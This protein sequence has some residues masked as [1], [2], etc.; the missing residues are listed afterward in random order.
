MADDPPFREGEP[1]TA[2]L[3][4]KALDCTV[5]RETFEAGDPPHCPSS[6]LLRRR[7][8]GEEIGRRKFQVKRR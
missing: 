6:L 4:G 5:V 1:V 2:Y 3:D 7:D 8:T